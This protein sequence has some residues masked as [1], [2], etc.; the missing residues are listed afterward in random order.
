MSPLLFLS[1]PADEVII[2]KIE[3]LDSEKCPQSSASSVTL[4][5]ELEELVFWGP[6]K[7]LLFDSQY[8]SPVQ[9]G[10]QSMDRLVPSTPRG[11]RS[12]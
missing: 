2:F 10:N 7:T 6:S 4:A 8:G 5:R 12:Q 1:V 9:Q 11:R 3:Q